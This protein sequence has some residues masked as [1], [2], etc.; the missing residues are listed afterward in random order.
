MSAPLINVV[1]EPVEVPAVLE[2]VAKGLLQ[3]EVGPA[4]GSETIEQL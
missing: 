1:L 2:V 3:H 4:G